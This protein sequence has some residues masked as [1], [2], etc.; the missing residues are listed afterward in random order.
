MN[1]RDKRRYDVFK[2]VQTFGVVN[3]ADFAKGSLA[4]ANFAAIDQ[5]I[6]GLDEAKAGQVGN[7]NTSMETLLNAVKLDLHNIA[8]TAAAIDQTEPGF[9]DS[10]GPPSAYNPGALLTAADAFLLQLAVQPGDSAAVKTAKAAL[11]AKFAAHEMNAS[12]VTVLQND[13]QA[14][15]D[16]QSAM[17]S[18][19]EDRVGNTAN[20]SPLIQQGMA[21]VNTL[22]AIMHN[23]YG[24][25]PDTMAAWATASH[26]ERAAQSSKVK[27]PAPPAPPK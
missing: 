21:A 25:T 8:R 1:V 27:P 7:A 19:S 14:I 13:R 11:V 5:V 2:R 12:F 15:T 20:I 17:E 3:A 18:D 4:L 26:V 16:E 6:T 24:S 10:F 22:D 9:A 23:K